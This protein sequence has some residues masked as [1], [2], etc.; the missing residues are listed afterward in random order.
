MLHQKICFFLHVSGGND[1]AVCTFQSVY[2]EFCIF[3]VYMTG[4]H[5]N[6][7]A[8][9]YWCAMNLG[10][11]LILHGSMAGHLAVWPF[12][13]IA[14]HLA[15]LNKQRHWR[16]LSL[17]V[18]LGSQCEGGGEDESP[19]LSIIFPPFPPIVLPPLPTLPRILRQ[20]HFGTALY[21]LA[22]VD[23]CMNR[24]VGRPVGMKRLL[25]A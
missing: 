25:S 10:E 17:R 14:C 20:A 18:E 21:P 19:V 4:L 15:N 5:C 13:K 24:Q 7:V 3:A 6:Y 11:W 23:C 1:G 2:C 12:K 9:R 16:C 22:D 8:F